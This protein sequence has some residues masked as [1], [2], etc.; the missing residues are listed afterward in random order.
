MTCR[1]YLTVVVVLAVAGWVPGSARAQSATLS[2]SD[3]SLHR[4][5]ANIEFDR[6]HAVRFASRGG[7]RVEGYGISVLG[8]SLSVDTD[9]GSRKLAIVDIDSLWVQRG[10]AALT[11]GILVALP[12]AVFGALVGSF[13]ATDPDS[14]G[15]PGHGFLG[16]LIGFVIGGAPCGLV[17]AALGSLIRPWRLEFARTAQVAIFNDVLQEV[18]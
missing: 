8:D 1:R 16:G 18:S 13:L 17:G 5:I 11:V 12:C 3:W 9:Q 15:R 2:Y 7:G 14:G 10:T 6:P 4:A